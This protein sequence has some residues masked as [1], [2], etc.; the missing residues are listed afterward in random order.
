MS[1]SGIYSVQARA[2]GPAQC[3]TN[4]SKLKCRDRVLTFFGLGLTATH[5]VGQLYMSKSGFYSV[6]AWVEVPHSVGQF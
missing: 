3:R 6:Q 2:D 5:G 4:L 1:K